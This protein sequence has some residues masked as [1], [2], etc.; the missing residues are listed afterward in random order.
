MDGGIQAWQ[1]MTADGPPEGEAAYFAPGTGPAEMA[2]LAWAL[3]ENTRLFYTSL[4]GIRPGTDEADLFMKLAD[5]EEHHKESLAAMHDRYSDEPIDRFLQG[6]GTPLLEGGVGME[7]A[8]SWAEDKPL[9]KVMAAV[10]GFEANAYDRYLKMVD[11][12][13]NEDA[14]EI[15]R[16]IAKEEKEH[17]GRLSGLLDKKIKILNINTEDQHPVPGSRKPG[18][19]SGDQ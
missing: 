7:E 17:L 18:G 4:A 8:L 13:E 14:K 6:Q 1:G 16:I 12:A 11:V 5:A 2:S 3:E 19:T 9:K 15:F 10:M